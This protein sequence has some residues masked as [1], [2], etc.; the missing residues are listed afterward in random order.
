[1]QRDNE[2]G[3]GKTA[4]A[5]GAGLRANEL[6]PHTNGQTAV[7]TAQLTLDTLAAVERAVAAPAAHQ[8]DRVPEHHATT[9]K[10]LK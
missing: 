8:V 9:K 7:P 4:V 3:E 1:M 5:L 2:V 10:S 6:W